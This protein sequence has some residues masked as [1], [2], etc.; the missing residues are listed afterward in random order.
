MCTHGQRGE[1]IILTENLVQN[2][3][4]SG[5][6]GVKSI[7]AEKFLFQLVGYQHRNSVRARMFGKLTD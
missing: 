3:S 7:R 2:A 5:K 4:F 1:P 6:T